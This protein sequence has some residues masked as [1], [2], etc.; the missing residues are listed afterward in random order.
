MQT[1]EQLKKPNCMYLFFKL[2]KRSI[3]VSTTRLINLS[4][5][6]SLEK[7]HE[8]VNSAKSEFSLTIT[9]NGNP[10]GKFFFFYNC[11]RTFVPCY[12]N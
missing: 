10:T 6:F 12:P 11:R 7:C 1:G 4:F 3:H 2:I 8:Y 5:C 9:S